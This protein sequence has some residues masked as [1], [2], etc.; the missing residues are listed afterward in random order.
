MI[1]PRDILD[2]MVA[3]LRVGARAPEDVLA[4]V[5]D[6][7]VWD[8]VT[9]SRLQADIHEAHDGGRLTDA[10]AGDLTRGIEAWLSSMADD[11]P[12]EVIDDPAIVAMHLTRV[13]RDEPS[14]ELRPGVVLGERYLLGEPVARGGQSI[15]FRARV[16]RDDGDG[17]ASGQPV[18]IKVLKDAHP[19]VAAVAR[20]KREFRQ[21]QALQH[22]GVANMF[23]I[24]CDRGTWFIAMELLEGMSL[25]TRLN[26]VATQ[27]L[28]K[29]EAL[30]IVAACADVLTRAHRLGFA[31]GDVKPGN[32]F[33]QEDGALKV[34][35]FGAAYDVR[36]APVSL[37]NEARVSSPAATRTY[38]SPEVLDGLVAEARD[39]I[40]SLAC[41]AYEML[42]GRHPYS[43]MP[44]SEA[45]GRA[46]EF[47][48]VEGLTPRQNAALRSALEWSRSRRP[49]SIGAWVDA[50]L[51]NAPA[52]QARPKLATIALTPADW[53][54]WRWIAAVATVATALFVVI[55]WNARSHDESAVSP[56]VVASLP[57]EQSPLQDELSLDAMPSSTDAAD[58]PQTTVAAPLAADPADGMSTAAPPTD[59]AARAPRPATASRARIEADA[60]SISS[61]EG[62][63]SAVVVLRRRGNVAAA[64]T[65]SWLLHEGSAREGEDYTIPANRSARFSAGQTT[66][67][68][69]VPLVNDDRPEPEES[70]SLSFQSPRAAIDTDRVTIT[71]LDDD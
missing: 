49:P 55:W 19:S 36:P 25:R 33:L 16:L 15:V 60:L 70:L 23:D 52:A 28:R 68:I 41:V 1:P 26:R 51:D 69:Y 31:H 32:L 54:P 30:Q 22:A 20:L 62:A 42:A 9:A 58:A 13:S 24:G 46:I 5:R 56:T 40:F 63:P 11:D 47:A 59:A 17:A 39:D 44:A 66:R 37:A 61:P 34:L 7:W 6:A 10:E 50:L 45:R 14:L 71:I 18:A 12:T 57:G 27:P 35:D 67:A 4:H 38:A 8:E 2:Y 29:P 21:T 3:E 53:L 43:R 65:V 48:P 64:L